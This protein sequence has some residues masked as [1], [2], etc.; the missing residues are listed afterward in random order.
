[1]R[2]RE[3]ESIGL[4]GEHLEKTGVCL[5]EMLKTFNAYLDGRREEAKDFALQV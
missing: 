2:K 4:A 1:M 5:N 3:E